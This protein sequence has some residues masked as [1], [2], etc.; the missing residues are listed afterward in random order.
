MRSLLESANPSIDLTTDGHV[1]TY[2]CNHAQ[3]EMEDY[4]KVAISRGLKTVTFLEHLET[5]IKHPDRIWLRPED[6]EIYFSDGKR[7]KNKYKGQIEIKIGIEAGFNQNKISELK[8]LLNQYPSDYTGLSYHFLF[9]GKN[10]L[11]MVSRREENIL[12]LVNLGIDYVLTSYFE[13]L[14]QGIDE[15][16]IDVLCHLD[17]VLRHYPNL[18]FTNSHWQQLEHLLDTLAVK[19]ISLEINTSGFAIRGEPFPSSKILEMAKR[20]GVRMSA[21]SDAHHPEQVGRYF[22]RLPS[23]IENI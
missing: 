7:L 18:R 17:A 13:G 23:L 19:N 3:G 6:F 1:H 21:G 9:D 4:V 16:E 12:A 8:Q 5:G 2:L 20:K 10:H 11:N 22:N 14:Q 15:L